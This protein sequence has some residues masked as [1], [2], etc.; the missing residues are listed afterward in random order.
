MSVKISSWCCCSCCK[1]RFHDL[2]RMR[3]LRSRTNRKMCRIDVTAIAR[4]SSIRGRETNPRWGR[5][6]CLAN[7]VVVGIEEVSELRR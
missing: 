4:I 6:N 7:R 2:S 1:P 5:G 3:Q